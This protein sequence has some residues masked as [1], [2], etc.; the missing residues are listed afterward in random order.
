MKFA[1]PK[2]LACLILSIGLIGC[3]ESTEAPAVEE[4]AVTDAEYPDAATAAPEV[5]SVL[6]ENDRVR[7]LEMKLPIGV[8]DEMHTHPDEAAFFIT[9]S[10]IKIHMPDGETIEMVI[11][12][13]HPFSHEAWSHA[14]ENF[15]KTDLHA[16]VVEIMDGGRENA[17]IVPEGMAADA[18]SPDVYTLLFEDDRVRIIEMKLAAGASDAEHVHPFEAVYFMTGG[19]L[20]ITVPE[21][22]PIEAEIPDG[23]VL[24]HEMWKHSVEN[25]GDTDVHA[26]IVE[27][28]QSN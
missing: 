13:G 27:L 6:T 20:R 26:I 28:V 7:M 14:V 12:D 23:G 15:G 18:I 19:K 4:A 9:G 24:T 17:G 21:G 2:L 11:P 10:A 25:I 8:T 5:Y 16:I 22:D 3:A 1:L